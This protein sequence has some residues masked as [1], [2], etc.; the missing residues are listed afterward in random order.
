MYLY[1][2]FS[3][4]LRMVSARARRGLGGVRA[5]KGRKRPKKFEN[6]RKI[7][8]RSRAPKTLE[9]VPFCEP[10]SGPPGPPFSSFFRTA[11]SNREFAGKGHGVSTGASF[12]PS[13]PPSNLLSF[14]LLKR[15][16]NRRFSLSFSEP[17]SALLLIANK[18]FWVPRTD[19]E[20]SR[21]SSS[22]GSFS[23]LPALGP[24]SDDFR[25]PEASFR[26]LRGPPDRFKN[27]DFRIF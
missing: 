19:L 4:E 8:V 25:A 23:Y 14:R 26:A 13:Q 11:T 16:K 24:E 10:K 17:R 22:R 2:F 18:R 7:R 1:N 9:K 15:S 3:R 6:A 21:F 27:Q 12:R 5:R 20:N